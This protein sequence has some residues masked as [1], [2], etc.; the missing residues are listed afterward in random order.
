MTWDQVAFVL[1]CSMFAAVGVAGITVNAVNG[2]RTG[3]IYGTVGLGLS[4][5]GLVLEVV[6]RD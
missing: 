1:M 4:L 5:A 3:V 2:D 6:R